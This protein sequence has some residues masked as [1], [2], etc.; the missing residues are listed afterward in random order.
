MRVIKYNISDFAGIKNLDDFYKQL[1]LYDDL[2]ADKYNVMDIYMEQENCEK[3]RDFMF[4]NF[5]KRRYKEQY[6]KSSI[7]MHW[8][9][10]SPSSKLIVPKDEIWVD[11]NKESNTYGKQDN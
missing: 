7:A 6:I 2:V 9:D 10:L 3:L 1:E 11:D 4:N 5:K 8:V